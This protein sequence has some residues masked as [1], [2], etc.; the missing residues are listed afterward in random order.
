MILKYSHVKPTRLITMNE[1]NQMYTIEFL[2]ARLDNLYISLHTWAL[3]YFLYNHG[4]IIY[5]RFLEIDAFL[6]SFRFPLIY[7]SLLDD[8]SFND[9]VSNTLNLIR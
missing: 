2:R 1:Y 5:F 9:Q 8:S 6:N 3:I 7:Y 4:I